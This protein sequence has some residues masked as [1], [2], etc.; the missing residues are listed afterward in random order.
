MVHINTQ[1]LMPHIHEFTCYQPLKDSNGSWSALNLATSM[2]RYPPWTRY[3]HSKK[4]ICLSSTSS[5]VF[6]CMIAMAD[7]IEQ[8][9]Y[10]VLSS[11]QHSSYYSLAYAIQHSEPDAQWLRP[12]QS[13][14]NETLGDSIRY[15]NKLPHLCNFSPIIGKIT[16]CSCGCLLASAHLQDTLPA[17]SQGGATTYLFQTGRS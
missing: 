7:I 11:W 1:W 12:K 4:S 6:T 14:R 16:V 5:F 15:L 17:T 10:F 2:E 3:D 13:N 9:K 8:N